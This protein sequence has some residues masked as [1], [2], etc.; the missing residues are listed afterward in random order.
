M[1]PVGRFSRQ[2]GL[3][4]D[5]VCGFWAVS[6]NYITLMQLASMISVWLGNLHCQ[7]CLCH[8]VIYA[9]VERTFSQMNLIKIQTS[10]QNASRITGIYIVNSCQEMGCVLVLQQLPA[11]CGHVC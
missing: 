4:L 5:D 1:L 11:N 10:E 8:S 6:F 2:I 7:S 3:V 9:A